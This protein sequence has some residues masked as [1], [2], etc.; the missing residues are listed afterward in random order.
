MRCGP[1]R[2]IFVAFLMGT[3]LPVG[4]K[5]RLRSS[6]QRKLLRCGAPKTTLLFNNPDWN[7]LE[8]SGT[9]TDTTRH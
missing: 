8:A 4:T 6:S 5:A 3:Q 9:D 2:N 7:T 1:K